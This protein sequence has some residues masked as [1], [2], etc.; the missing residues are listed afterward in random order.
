MRAAAALLAGLLAVP[1][2]ACELELILAVDVSG[3]VN[4][5][6]YRLQTEGMAAAFRAPAVARAVAALDG[7]MIVSVTQWS[8]ISRQAL[9]LDWTHLAAPEQLH[10]FAGRIETMPRR[11]R[12]FSTAIGEALLNAEAVSAGAPLRCARRVV[13][14]SGDG[15]SNEGVSPGPIARRLAAGGH[16]IN[17]LVIRGAD[18][19]PAGHYAREVIAGPGAFVELAEGFADFPRAFLRKLLRELEPPMI[20]SDG[21]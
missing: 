6:E 1:A 14:V 2:P 18:P 5:Q 7:G 3:S 9:I 20:L 13:D 12:S 19:D 17:G 4:A 11:W 8:G 10:A 21:H 15:V 16:T